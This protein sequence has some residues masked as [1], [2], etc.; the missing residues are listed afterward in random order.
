MLK[1]ER[2]DETRLQGVLRWLIRSI[3]N[4]SVER[5]LVSLDKSLVEKEGKGDNLITR[6]HPM[7]DLQ[8]SIILVLVDL[9]FSGNFPLHTPQREHPPYIGGD[10]FEGQVR[11][12]H[13]GVDHDD[14][15]AVL[16]DVD[17]GV[18]HLVVVHQFE[19]ETIGFV[20]VL[21]NVER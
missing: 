8:L 12:L 16:V 11:V 19:G 17:G 10:V 20:R 2:V 13:V 7:E 15:R 9:V 3:L 5:S 21:L 6:V 1:L 4:L 14:A 18:A